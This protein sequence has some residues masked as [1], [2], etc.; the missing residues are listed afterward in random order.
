MRKQLEKD[1]VGKWQTY[2][3]KINGNLLTKTRIIYTFDKF[4]KDI[5]I[6]NLNGN[7]AALCQFKILITDQRVRS[8]SYVQSFN[9]NSYKKLLDNFI[10]M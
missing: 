8:I 1:K 2:N 7:M 4:W 6:P 5:I 9:V 3:E 10:T